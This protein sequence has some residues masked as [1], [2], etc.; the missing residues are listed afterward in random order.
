MRAAAKRDANEAGI[1]SALE[2]SGWL[3][4]RLS[5][6]GLPDL[7]CVRRGVLV[8]LEVKA[9]TGTLTDIQEALFVRL[10]RWGYRVPVVR[11]PEDA[12][13]ACERASR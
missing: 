11:T 3:V 12:L 10:L 8:L 2:A 6:A 4:L 7:L 5:G 1:V 9:A 13:A